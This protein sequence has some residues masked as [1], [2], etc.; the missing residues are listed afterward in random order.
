MK[1]TI[2]G[3]TG[4]TGRLLVSA[5]LAAGHEVTAFARR[6][7]TL[8]QAPGLTIIEADVIDGPAVARA[9]TGRDAVLSALGGKPFKALGICTRAMAAIIPAMQ[10][11]GVRRII[12]MS[13]FGAGETRRDVGWFAQ[14]LLFRFVLRGEVA[15][16]NKMEQLL[17]ASPLDWTVVRV[18]R[19]IDGA[20]GGVRAADDGT[21][22]VMRTVARAD[23]ARFMVD[24]L[25][26]NEWIRRKPVVVAG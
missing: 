25:T 18:N 7:S 11:H 13:T 1:V 24:E 2:F 16:K 8:K 22:K 14:H 4:G 26:R 21:I 15:D 19:L 3:A 6:S 20:A 5:A 10:R 12:A 17:E 23:V 9:I